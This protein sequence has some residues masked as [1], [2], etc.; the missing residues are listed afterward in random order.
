MEILKIYKTITET[1][2]V[3]ARVITKI[4]TIKGYQDKVSFAVYYDDEE[5]DYEQVS[6]LVSTVEEAEKQ[7]EYYVKVFNKGF[8]R[9]VNQNEN[10]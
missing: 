7:A 3:V 8:L 9:G 1:W 2:F 4:K 5:S 10:T 6:D